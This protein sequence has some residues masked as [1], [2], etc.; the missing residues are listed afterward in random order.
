MKKLLNLFMIL[1]LLYLMILI[2]LKSSLVTSSVIF[3][4]TLWINNI[5]PSLF[6]F[7]IFSEILINY[8]FVELISEIFKPFMNKVFKCSAYSSFIFVM[9]IIS[10]I[11]SNAKY[12]KKLYDNNLID[13][14]EG[15]K[16][17]MFTHFSNPLF[18]LGTV[19]IMFLNNKEVGF[20]I[21]LIHY[22][23]NIII[24]VIFRNYNKSSNVNQ[25]VFLNNAYNNMYIRRLENKNTFGGILKE[26]LLNSI[27][28]LLLILGIVTFFIIITTLVNEIFNFNPIFQATLNGII[29]MTQGLKYIGNLNI[30]LKT[31]TII[32][33][34]LL[35]FG[36]FSSHMQVMSILSDTKIK[37]FPYFVAR[38][39]HS[40][41]SSILMFF[42]FD[43]YFNL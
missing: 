33:T 24:G 10:G 36:G 38:L 7:F 14:K 8:G 2:L 22:I 31:K 11:P 19:S 41:L 9:S 40:L 12:I 32:S 3:S 30:P 21:L 16:I 28:T 17:L 42:I 25:K 29:E 35:S 15:T 20:L 13:D 5:V 4:F 6:P 1:I 43:F 34:F 39:I 23:T 18:I 27:N 37:Y 26:A